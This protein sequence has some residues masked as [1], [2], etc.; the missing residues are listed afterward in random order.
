MTRVGLK[1]HKNNN[2]NKKSY[3]TINKNYVETEKN[4]SRNTKSRFEALQALLLKI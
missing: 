4:S 2:N 1:R 3:K